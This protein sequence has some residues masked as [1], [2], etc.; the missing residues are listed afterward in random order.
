[1]IENESPAPS[2]LPF[3][4]FPG[5]FPHQRHIIGKRVGLMQEGWFGLHSQS[6]GM[7]TLRFSSFSAAAGGGA[8]GHPHVAG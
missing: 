7:Q 3:A 4:F 5:G 2:L 8:P 6:S 1:M